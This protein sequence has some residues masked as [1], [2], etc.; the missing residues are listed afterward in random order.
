[1]TTELR[2]E[3]ISIKDAAEILKVPCSRFYPCKCRS[4]RTPKPK[5]NYVPDKELSATIKMACNRYPLYD[6]RR[7]CVILRRGF[8]IK[9]ISQKR[10]N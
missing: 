5:Q 2:K 10:V 6:Y 8:N 3:G 4:N 7:I 9:N 1:L